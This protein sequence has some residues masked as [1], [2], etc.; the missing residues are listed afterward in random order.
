MHHV[1]F[2]AYRRRLVFST[3]NVN[4]DYQ[5]KWYCSLEQKKRTYTYVLTTFV[6]SPLSCNI[7]VSILV[8]RI[9]IINE[10]II[11]LRA[12]LIFFRLSKSRMGKTFCIFFEDGAHDI[13]D[14]R[15]NDKIGQRSISGQIKKKLRI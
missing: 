12:D 6:I 9:D 3:E 2:Y 10:I 14:T 1:W 7:K 4:I 13:C 8:S 11:H 15:I 5:C